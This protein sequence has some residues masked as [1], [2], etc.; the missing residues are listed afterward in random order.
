MK[1]L[2]IRSIFSVPKAQSE[3]HLFIYCMTV[4]PLG[5]TRR[6]G[7][8]PALKKFPHNIFIPRLTLSLEGLSRAGNAVPGPMCCGQAA[9]EST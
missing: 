2:K 9:A 3:C 8:S 5:E 6:E 1:C 7:L 4:G